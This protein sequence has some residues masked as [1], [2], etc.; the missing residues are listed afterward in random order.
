MMNG[1]IQPNCLYRLYRLC[2]TIAT[3]GA[4][5]TTN[6]DSE[7]D[8][9][10]WHLRQGHLTS[11]SIVPWESSKGWYSSGQNI[12]KKKKNKNTC[13]KLYSLRCIK[14]ITG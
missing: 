10:R 1:E 11:A 13:A 2:G 3:G 5:I 8:T 14:A 6:K 4:S 12:K 7:D 9:Q